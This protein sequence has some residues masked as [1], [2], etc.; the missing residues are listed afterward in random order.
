HDAYVQM[1]RRVGHGFSRFW[2][3]D[4]GCLYDVLD[5]PQGA[6]PSVRP[7]QLLALSLP[8]TPLAAVRRRAVLEAC[9]RS[10]LTPYG[11]RSLAPEDSRYARGDGDA[12]AREAAR[13]QGAAWVWLL[14]HYGLAHYRV[15]RERAA[16]LALLEPLGEL[17]ER[18]GLGQLP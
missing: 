4:T 18:Y 11:L 13:H 10:L 7:N 15:H 1:A 16:A 5:G 2:N 12:A 8:D 9:A 17:L 3:A 6:D 14:P